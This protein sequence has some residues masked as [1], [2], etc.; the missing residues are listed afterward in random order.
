MRG[1]DGLMFG[2]VAEGLNRGRWRRVAMAA[3]RCEM[4]PGHGTTAEIRNHGDQDEKPLGT[5]GTHRGVRVRAAH[6]N[7]NGL[8]GISRFT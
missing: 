3:V 7:L 6:P 2:A 4:R 8:S 1:R 5:L